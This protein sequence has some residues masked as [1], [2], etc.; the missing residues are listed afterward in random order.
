MWNSLF[1]EEELPVVR[2]IQEVVRCATEF[3]ETGTAGAT[4][5]G[6]EWSVKPT[7]EDQ[8]RLTIVLS[9]PL[10]G[11]GVFDREVSV[12]RS[13]FAPAPRRKGRK[14][15]RSIPKSVKP[16]LSRADPCSLHWPE[17]AHAEM[18]AR[19]QVAVWVLRQHC[20]VHPPDLHQWVWIECL[21]PVFGLFSAGKEALDRD[22]LGSET[23]PGIL[24]DYGRLQEPGSFQMYV[25][26]MAIERSSLTRKS[27]WVETTPISE[28]LRWWE[29]QQ[30]LD[31]VR[32]RRSRGY[33][34]IRLR[35]H[36]IVMKLKTADGLRCQQKY[37]ELRREFVHELAKEMERAG[38]RRESAE[39][40]LRR[41]AR[42]TQSL[43]GA[44]ERFLMWCKRKS[45][46][47]RIKEIRLE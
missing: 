9:G 42:E 16:Y 5:E 30:Y 31:F 47:P 22:A 44:L 34:G 1:Q 39:R 15:N 40:Q 26:Q 46:T 19:A 41:W 10:R 4:W 12:Y 18:W 36:R 20:W 25:R 21:E 6:E 35:G 38:A 23:L 14:P 27:R 2:A 33:A 13:G 32:K 45:Y 29:E 28:G 3:W 8:E 43:P 17:R 11:G 7:Y 37:A 24:R